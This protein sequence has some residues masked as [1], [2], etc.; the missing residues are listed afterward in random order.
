M[1]LVEVLLWRREVVFLRR[2]FKNVSLEHGPP[3]ATQPRARRFQAPQAPG[4][5]STGSHSDEIGVASFLWLLPQP[6]DV[7]KRRFAGRTFKDRA[8]RVLWLELVPLPG[9]G[10]LPS[11][12]CPLGPSPASPPGPTLRHWIRPEP[13][14]PVLCCT[15]LADGEAGGK[16]TRPRMRGLTPADRAV[17]SS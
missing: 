7:R 5:G 13:L 10:R 15:S 4:L 11:A 17:V 6:G 16:R 12:P 2:A 14:D 9:P 3:Q 1:I 8:T